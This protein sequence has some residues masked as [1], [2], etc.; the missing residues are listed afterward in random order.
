MGAAY[1]A[2]DLVFHAPALHAW[3]ISIFRPASNLVPYPMP[4]ATVVNA[5]FLVDHKAVLLE[6]TP[7]DR[8]CQRLLI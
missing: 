7:Y 3:R 6:L 1:T 8:L 4:G 2:A 5:D